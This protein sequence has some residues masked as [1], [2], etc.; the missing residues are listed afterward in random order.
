[1]YKAMNEHVSDLIK[2]NCQPIN[3]SRLKIHYEMLSDLVRETDRVISPLILLSIGSNIY[4]ICMYLLGGLIPEHDG[5]LNAIHFFGWF[6]LLVIKTVAVI[7]FAARINDESKK[8]ILLLSKCPVQGPSFEPQWLQLQLS[9]DE[10]ALTAM[11]FF[12]F[13]NF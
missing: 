2:S 10:V 12:Q 11:K 6:G 7:L 4:F 5:I 13:E 9:I 8:P 1:M 3:W